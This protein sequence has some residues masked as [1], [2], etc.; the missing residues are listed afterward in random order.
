MR[1][2]KKQHHHDKDSNYR[3]RTEPLQAQHSRCYMERVTENTS[4]AHE[5]P[6]LNK[7]NFA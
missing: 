2:A 4:T 1:M 3:V 7:Q 6:P 5:L